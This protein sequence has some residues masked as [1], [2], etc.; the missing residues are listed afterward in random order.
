MASG[1][2]NGPST[3]PRRRAYKAQDVPDFKQRLN[4]AAY[5]SP[6]AKV[7]HVWLAIF[8]SWP[9]E[10]NLKMS[11][12]S[13]AA[14]HAKHGFNA[15]SAPPTTTRHSSP[16]AEDAPLTIMMGPG[17]ASN[18]ARLKPKYPQERGDRITRVTARTATGAPNITVCPYATSVRAAVCQHCTSSKLEPSPLTRIFH[19][20]GLYAQCKLIPTA[21]RRASRLPVHVTTSPSECASELHQYLAPGEAA[22]S[23]TK[24][25]GSLPDE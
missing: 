9:C 25:N 2:R 14:I 18:T 15:M 23:A 21:P 16:A 20:P 3:S 6:S 7:A 13:A 1:H 4:N 17:S 12:P 8:T 22:S 11:A 24:A 10:L 19:Y 5:A